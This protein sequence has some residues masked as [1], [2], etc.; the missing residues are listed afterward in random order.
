L[1]NVASHLHREDSGLRLSLTVSNIGAK[2]D[3]NAQSH[4]VVA[5]AVNFNVLNAVQCVNLVLQ[6]V[7]IAKDAALNVVDAA[8]AA[9]QNA[10]TN[11]K[12]VQ[13]AHA[14]KD[15][16]INAK[17]APPNV[18][19]VKGAPINARLVLRDVLIVKPAVDVNALI[20]NANVN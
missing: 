3:I 17:H 7:V 11:V 8:R 15:A 9:P 18:Q 19:I 16:Q 1:N 2:E 6:N 20:A 14:A 4:A 13:N 12:L 5:F 10:Q